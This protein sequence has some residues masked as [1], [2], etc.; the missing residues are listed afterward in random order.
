[1]TSTAWPAALSAARLHVVTGKGGT[2]K[3]TVAAALALALATGGKR[4]LLIEVEGRQG[5]AQLFDTP[6]LP[7]EERKIAVAPGGGEVRA[8]A[9]DAEA[10]LLEYF[11]LFYRL[12]M[13][14]RT[15]RRMGAIEFATTLA[16]GLRD[17]LLTGKVKECVGRK[18][19]DGS[20]VYDAV[21]LDAPPTGRVVSFLDVTAA[22]A[23]LAK[24][25]PI[26]TQAKGVVE[27]LHSPLTAV[28]L[29]T[30]LED[31]P[32]TET[33]ETVD[34]L[35]AKGMRPG[36]VVANQ[37]RP[38]WL[39]DRSVAA[40]AGG[41]VDADRIRS[42]LASAGLDLPPD[43]IDGLVAETVEHA[44]RVHG[45]AMAL[46]RLDAEPVRPLPRIELPRVI[47]GID[48]GSLYEL[49]EELR[50]YGVGAVAEVSA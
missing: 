33:L 32:V 34:E 42:G 25:G 29:V 18:E 31:L 26:H 8:L 28:H 45:E 7:Y 23:D 41:R 43:V 19:R 22:M 38:Q 37:V 2:G 48:L 39:P 20:P 49:A 50:E 47:E 30:L 6:P 4:T 1:M 36:V 24:S 11:E 13:A 12:G 46:A 15:L 44:V 10:A 5:I 16:P 17:V 14:G 27:L 21:V 40:A 9:I 3:T 35:S